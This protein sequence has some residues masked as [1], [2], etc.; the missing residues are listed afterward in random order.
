MLSAPLQIYREMTDIIRLPQAY[1][2]SITIQGSCSQFK[3]QSTKFKAQR[4]LP[5]PHYN[6]K[7]TPSKGKSWR[8]RPRG[9]PAAQSSPWPASGERR[10]P[11]CT[12]PVSPQPSSEG[13]H[14]S[15][16]HWSQSGPSGKWRF[17]QTSTGPGRWC[18]LWPGCEGQCVACQ[19]PHASSSCSTWESEAQEVNTIPGWLEFC[20]MTTYIAEPLNVD[21]MKYKNLHI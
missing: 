19:E 2:L 10:A 5:V 11:S 1:S 15:G 8:W 9:A 17:P 4:F 7:L 12:P 20:T 14:A 3:V 16:T 21:F 18:P 13:S 6:K